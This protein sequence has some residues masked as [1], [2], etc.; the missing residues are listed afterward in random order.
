MMVVLLWALSSGCFFF[1]VQSDDKI[2][3]NHHIFYVNMYKKMTPCHIYD[4]YCINIFY[5]HV[6]SNFDIYA[7][8]GVDELTH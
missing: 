8:H 4:I 6:I 7:Y 3:R 1:M 2:N 5:G